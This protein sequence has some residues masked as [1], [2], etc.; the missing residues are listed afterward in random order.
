[1]TIAVVGDRAGLFGRGTSG[2]GCDAADLRLPGVQRELLEALLDTGRPV[3]VVL[4]TGRPYALGGIAERAAAVLQ[5]FFPGQEGG[6]AI[7]EVLT[8]AV[9]PSGRLPVGIPRDPGGQP[10]TY[11]TAPLGQRSG[12]SNIDPTPLYPFGHGL[13]YTDF[14][15]SGVEILGGAEEWPVDSAVEVAVTVTNTGE[16]SGADVVQLYAHDPVAQVVR[17][18]QRLVGFQRVAL[19]PGASARVVLTVHADL[20]SFTGRA[21]HRIVEPGAVQLRVARSSGDVVAELD[22]VSVGAERRVGQ[23]RELLA[24]ARVEAF[25][26]VPV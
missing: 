14:A 25:E 3:V 1:M 4:L 26:A 18:V 24:T 2:E 13:G 23:D 19:E 6:P 11:L 10:G 8:G 22:L 9:S 7:A 16:R 12:V 20:L 17:P 5:G 15:W 21:G